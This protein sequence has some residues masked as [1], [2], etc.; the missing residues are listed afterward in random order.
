[1]GRRAL[2]TR[3]ADPPLRRSADPLCPALRRSADYADTP[4]IWPL[5]FPSERTMV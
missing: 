5:R 4:K 2:P 3:H 1:M